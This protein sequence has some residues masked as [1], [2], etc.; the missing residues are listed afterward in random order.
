M[1]HCFYRIFWIQ[2]IQWQCQ[3]K[4]KNSN[5]LIWEATRGNILHYIHANNICS[6]GKEDAVFLSVFALRTECV[7][8]RN[9]ST[10]CIESRVYMFTN[11]T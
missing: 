7:A 6:A 9:Q 10:R 2:W 4:R 5:I 1:H 11:N 3:L 8:I